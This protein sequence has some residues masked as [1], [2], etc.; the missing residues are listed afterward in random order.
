MCLI[1]IP[2]TLYFSTNETNE[3]LQGVSAFVSF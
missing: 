2:K 3:T 1:M